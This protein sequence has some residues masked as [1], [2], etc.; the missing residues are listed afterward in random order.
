MELVQSPMSDRQRTYR[1]VYRDRIAT[2]YNGYLHIAIIYTIG[3]GV[4]KAGLLCSR[5]I[6]L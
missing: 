4:E 6:L 2:W 3:F 5:G 1:E